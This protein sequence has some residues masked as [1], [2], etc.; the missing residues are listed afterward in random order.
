MAAAGYGFY[1]YGER[2]LYFNALRYYKTAGVAAGFTFAG[3]VRL[4]AAVGFNLAHAC[5]W[6]YLK[7]QT[8]LCNFEAGFGAFVRRKTG[9]I[10][11]IRFEILIIHIK[12]SV[13]VASSDDP[14]Q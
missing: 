12:T 6:Q 8:Y 2:N 14:E 5:V 11:A 13:Y 1:A 4:A 7:R 9:L 3:H 10:N